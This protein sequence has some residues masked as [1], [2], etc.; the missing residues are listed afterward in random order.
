MLLNPVVLKFYL[1]SRHIIVLL[2][3]NK[4]HRP[5]KK[6]LH[7]HNTGNSFKTY[8]KIKKI[9]C[10]KFGK[11]QTSFLSLPC[12]LHI[13]TPTNH[14]SKC[15][16]VQGS[17][18]TCRSNK[19]QISKE[20]KERWC[21]TPTEQS[22]LAYRLCMARTNVV[23][24]SIAHKQAVSKRSSKPCN[25]LGKKKQTHLGITTIA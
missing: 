14:I 16:S 23:W 22:A 25:D 7:R 1:P 24:Q 18:A 10:P 2:E 6:S 11:K 5:N 12:V 19:I 15:P 3:Y 20:R 21:N 4:H 13:R 8:K 9:G 17:P